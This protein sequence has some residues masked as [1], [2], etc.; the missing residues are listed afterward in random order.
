MVVVRQLRTGLRGMNAGELK[1]S[2]GIPVT[3]STNGQESLAMI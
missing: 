3:N 1:V 2:G